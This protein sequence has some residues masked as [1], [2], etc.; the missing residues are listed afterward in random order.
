[1]LEATL[2][3]PQTHENLTIFPVLAGE[4]GHL[5][6][7]L[8]AEAL[9]MG[10]LAI[11]EKDGGQVPTLLATNSGFNPILILDGEQLIGAKQ[12]RMTNRSIILPA[13]S[14]TEVPVSC[15]EQGR[16][17]FVGE[18][19]APAPEHA[20]TRVRRKARETEARASYAAEARGPDARSSHRDLAQAQGEVWE[21]IRAFG[22]KLGGRSDTGALNSVFENRR[23]ELRRWVRAF[24]LLE[25]QIGLLAFQGG[26]PLGMDALGGPLLYG[27]VHERILT[28]YVMDA[29]EGMSGPAHRPEGAPDRPVRPSPKGAALPDRAS[30]FLRRTM[31]AS[32]VPSESVG[33]GE[34]RILRGKVVGGELVDEGKLVHLS[35]FP[36]EDRV[37]GEGGRRPGHGGL[38][39][40]GG[41]PIARPSRRRRRY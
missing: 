12:N 19:F 33:T 40:P 39:G 32:R 13:N 26:T 10:V 34:Y 29:M 2:G 31:R 4:G 36:A 17:H 14:I 11:R 16:W 8:M 6:Y 22:E 1:M 5:P 28:G 3:A 7:S 41:D 15:M 24:P 37:G 23:R 30:R 21:E 38:G 25:S 27:K 20:P 9:A 35:V 18:A